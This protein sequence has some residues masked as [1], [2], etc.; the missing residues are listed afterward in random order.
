MDGAV[1]RVLAADVRTGGSAKLRMGGFIKII[2][3]RSR[4]RLQG[5]RGRGLQHTNSETYK[6]NHKVAYLWNVGFAFVR[7]AGLE[8]LFEFVEEGEFG[9][10]AVRLNVVQVVLVLVYIWSCRLYCVYRDLRRR[11][12]VSGVGEMEAYQ[13]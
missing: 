2:T 3:I 1:E 4:T 8:A 6:G 7:A 9:F 12:V 11:R 5:G 10:A 13:W